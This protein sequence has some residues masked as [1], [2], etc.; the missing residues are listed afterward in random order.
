M[1]SSWKYHLFD[2][3]TCRTTKPMIPLFKAHCLAPGA[4]LTE[5]LASGMLGEG[6]VCAEFELALQQEFGH[7]HL[8]VLNSCTSALILA[9]RLSGVGSG[10]GVLTSPFTMAATTSAIVAVGARPVWTDVSPD[11][12][13]MAPSD[14]V[15]HLARLPK[16]AIVT[17]VGGLVPEAFE[18]ILDLGIPVILDCAHALATF[19]RGVHISHWGDY[20]CFSFQAI[21][22]LTTGD[23]GAVAI[24]AR[25]R[26]TCAEQQRDADHDYSRAVRLRWFGLRRE[27]SRGGRVD[28]QATQDITEFGYKFHM[29][30][31]AAAIGLECLPR[32][33]EAVRASRD[34]ANF[35]LSRLSGLSG[36]EL[37]TVPAYCA[38]SWWVF[39]LRATNAAGL[40]AHL[41]SKGVQASKLWRRN[42]SYSAVHSA[43]T[44]QLP[45]ADRVASEAVFI[46]SGWWLTEVQRC[47]VIDIITEFSLTAMAT[48]EI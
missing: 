31:V 3:Q 26:P 17:C 4:R 39:G 35:Y 45:G 40:I 8:L 33:R 43:N 30:D 24:N 7:K 42:D 21:K 34:T 46:P 27:T 23:G 14:D 44:T 32:A 1:F 18:H 6:P 38:P 22:H 5:V 37:L 47:Q 41:S 10:D 29:N 19:Y 16:A 20:A 36:I 11:T 2:T 12:F 9:L 48:K 15:L 25:R 28:V 13:C